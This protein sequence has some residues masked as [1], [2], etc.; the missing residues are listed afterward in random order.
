MILVAMSFGVPRNLCH[1][2][3]EAAGASRWANV[4]EAHRNL[5]VE[6]E[7]F[8]TQE[9]FMPEAVVPLHQLSLVIES[10][11]GILLLLD[12][13]RRWVKRQCMTMNGVG[14]RSLV[15]RRR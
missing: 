9:G 14:V 12:K 7:D 4:G 11:E 3:K 8:Q 10:R 15:G 6:G 5:T 13:R 1:G 2:S